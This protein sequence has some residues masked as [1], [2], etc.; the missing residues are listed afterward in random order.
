MLTATLENVLNR[1]LP[2]SPRAQRLC[3]ELAG[4]RVAIVIGLPTDS[5]AAAPLRQ[6]A[7]LVESTGMS[8][9]LISPTTQTPAAP[10]DATV[11]GGPFS[12]LALSGP[13]PE[14]VL[15][16]G[17]VRIDGD[18]E[19][20]EKFR[21]L[22]LLLRPDLEEELSLVLGDVPAHQMGRFVR[23]ALGWTRKAA[24]TTVRNVAE[25]L[26]H[27]QRDLIPR[28]EAEQFLRGVDTLREDVDRLAARIDLLTRP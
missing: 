15:Q 14:A 28:S 23:T 24:A 10:A 13:A 27:E 19:L 22:A 6:P 17:D 16:R 8:L 9:K 20:A 4:R 2:R 26:G 25:Y 3:A 18:A 11:T 12:L 21:E 1:G 5:A 7:V